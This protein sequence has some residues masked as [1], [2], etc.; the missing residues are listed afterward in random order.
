MRLLTH[1]VSGFCVATSFSLLLGLD[2]RVGIV[3]GILATLANYLIDAVGHSATSHGTRRNCIHS[4]LGVTLILATI[5]AM[6]VIFSIFAPPPIP[7]EMLLG[8]RT[9]ASVALGTYLH[10]LLDA[11]T[12]GGIYP[13]YPVSRKRFAVAHLDYDNPWINVAT[14]IASLALLV[15]ATWSRYSYVVNEVLKPWLGK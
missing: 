5:F 4:L 15:F 1:V 3:A 2:L 14:I 11:F 10:L 12:E 7:L 13:L 8:P 9:I 6:L